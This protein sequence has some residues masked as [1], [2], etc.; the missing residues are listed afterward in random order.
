ML[1]L[2]YYQ[3]LVTLFKL[4]IFR[5]PKQTFADTRASKIYT[6]QFDLQHYVKKKETVSFKVSHLHLDLSH[7]PIAINP[8]G[9]VSPVN[10]FLRNSKALGNKRC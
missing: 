8:K 2:E 10:L 9:I 7:N 1:G 4:E 3:T 6:W 5:S